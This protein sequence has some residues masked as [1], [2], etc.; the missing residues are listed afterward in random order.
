MADVPDPMKSLGFSESFLATRRARFL[1]VASRSVVRT[2]RC[3]I[4]FVM[5]FWSGPARQAFAALKQALA[6]VDPQGRLELVVVDTDGCPELYDLPEFGG[7]LAGAGET[8]W[9]NEGQ[10]VSTALR[11]NP[12]SLR[13]GTFDLLAKCG[14]E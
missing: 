4:L 8:A 12:Q 9:V 2:I 10:I 3:G 1:P 6:E 5:A 14:V 13:S 7:M 11:P